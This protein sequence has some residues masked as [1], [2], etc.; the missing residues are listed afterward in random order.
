MA[1]SEPQIAPSLLSGAG[2]QFVAQFGKQIGGSFYPWTA[3]GAQATDVLLD[4]IARSNGTRSSVTNALFTTNVR[5]GIIGSFMFTATG[6]TTG[7][8]VT[9]IRIQHGQGVPVGVITPSTRDASPR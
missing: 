3:Y 1:V 8:S 7:G 6:D 2:Q 4:A 9:I 5:N